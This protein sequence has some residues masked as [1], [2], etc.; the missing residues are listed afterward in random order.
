MEKL[1]IP[2]RTPLIIPGM[3]FVT[4]P[5]SLILW[6]FNP[7][8]RAPYLFASLFLL[9][10][11]LS[12]NTLLSQPKRT[13][14][15]VHR[16]LITQYYRHLFGNPRSTSYELKNFAAVR[17]YSTG[18][19]ITVFV[20]ELLSTSGDKALR[21]TELDP[22]GFFSSS[23]PDKAKWLRKTIASSCSLRDDGY[24]GF[25]YSS[26]PAVASGYDA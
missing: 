9:T 21:L 24:L 18:H 17:T 19:K 14:I 10:L 5:F 6:F 15:D 16:G 2:W 3:L 1:D 11:V 12:A 23:E 20:A 26:L 8:P 7:G 4:G 22:D 25:R 13:E